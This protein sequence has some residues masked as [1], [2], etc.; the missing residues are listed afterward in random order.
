MGLVIL[1]YVGLVA[2]R[3]GRGHKEV[4][5][6]GL[7]KWA[8]TLSCLWIGIMVVIG[9]VISFKNGDLP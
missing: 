8:V 5:S 9:L 7:G 4:G 1:F 3:A 2:F 6:H